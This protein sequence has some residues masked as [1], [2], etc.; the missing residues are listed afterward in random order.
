MLVND[1]SIFTKLLIRQKDSEDQAIDYGPQERQSR[2]KHRLQG[3]GYRLQQKEKAK[4][5]YRQQVTYGRPGQAGYSRASGRMDG[6]D[7]MD[8][9]DGMDEKQERNPKDPHSGNGL[10][11]SRD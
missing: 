10:A 8:E 3:R 5:G 4:A 7:R 11:R 6:V 9:M 1:Y 2:D